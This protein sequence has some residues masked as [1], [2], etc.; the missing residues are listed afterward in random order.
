MKVIVGVLLS[1]SLIWSCSKSNR[2]PR[3][4]IRIDD[5]F[6]III[7]EDLMESSRD[8]QLVL[9]TNTALECENY[10]IDYGLEVST[11]KIVLEINGVIPPNI[12]EGTSGYPIDTISLGDLQQNTYEFEVLIGGEINNYGKFEVSASSL[13][14]FFYSTNGFT[15]ENDSLLRIPYDLLWGTIAYE[16]GASQVADS[17]ID[18]L[19]ELDNG[20][21]LP[22]GNYGYFSLSNDEVSLPTENHPGNLKNFAFRTDADTSVISNLIDG[23]MVNYPNDINVSLWNGKGF[24]Y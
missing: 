22:S 12:C 3:P 18:E 10:E 13:K 23:Y 11:N 14:S 9:T 21:I 20:K 2:D 16:N 8:I 17:L 15:V 5:D 7:R 24:K 4:I 6:N 19:S 1:L